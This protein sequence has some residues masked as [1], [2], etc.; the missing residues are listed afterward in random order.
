MADYY[1][2]NAT[3]IE[4]GGLSNMLGAGNDGA[5]EHVVLDSYTGVA[6]DSGSTIQVGGTLP[7][8]AIITDIIVISEA[9]G[10]SQ[11]IAIG[12][13]DSGTRYLGATS[14]NAAAR[15]QMTSIG[16]YVI[17]TNAGDNKILLTVGGNAL[18]ATKTI[19]A[20]IKYV[21]RA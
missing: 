9:Q 14:V 5:V 3:K 7:D 18:D 10:N 15:L 17:G 6:A 2:A 12:D 13:S 16:G 11:T 1:G 8:G 19:W 21:Y 20:M 4:A